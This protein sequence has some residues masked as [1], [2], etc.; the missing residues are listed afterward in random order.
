MHGWFENQEGYTLRKIPS[1]RDPTLYEFSLS[2][3]KPLTF[4]WE[5]GSCWQPD[6]HEITD[7]GSL[8]RLAQLWIPKD[9]YLLSW[10]C[11]DSGYLKGGL[12][13]SPRRG[14][15]YEFVKM[16]RKQ[17]DD[18]MFEGIRSEGGTWLQL[19]AIYWA[20]RAGGWINWGDRRRK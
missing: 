9:R 5:D 4:I 2:R 19:E 6:R 10:M 20:V 17:I 16:P 7:M 12:Y 13:V 11:H 3:S 1:S 18:F 8:P 15:P 14:R